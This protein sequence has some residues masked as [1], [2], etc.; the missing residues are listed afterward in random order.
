MGGIAVDDFTSSVG[1]PEFFALGRQKGR[2]DGLQK[3]AAKGPTRWQA[4]GSQGS[5]I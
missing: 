1:Y 4:K 2:Q 3:G 5:T